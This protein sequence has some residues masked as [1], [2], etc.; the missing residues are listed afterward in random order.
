MKYAAK[1]QLKNVIQALQV[2]DQDENYAYVVTEYFQHGDLSDLTPKWQTAGAQER[3]RS[4]KH[5]VR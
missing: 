2:Q 1:K 4:A 5:I 3:E